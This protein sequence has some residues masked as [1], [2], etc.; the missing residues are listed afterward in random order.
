MAEEK[1]RYV[2]VTTEFRG[3][4]AGYATDVDG[5]VIKLRRGRN[6][7]YWSRDMRGFEGLAVF[8]PSESC[9]IGPAANIALRKITAVVECTPEAEAAW[10]SA[11]WKD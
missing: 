10:E 1:E 7:L 2:L 8:G 11:P 4:F 9:R 5:D 6:C 3:V